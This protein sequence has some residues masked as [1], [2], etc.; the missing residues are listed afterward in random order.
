METKIECPYCKTEFNYEPEDANQD[1]TL[2][3]DCPNEECEKVFTGSANW[4]FSINNIDKA[5]CL[6]GDTHILKPSLGI[7]DGY[8]MQYRCQLCD[9]HGSIERF[10]KHSI[11]TG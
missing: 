3:I 1:E 9:D 2:W 8:P 6:N 4:E 7:P 10:K 11:V 5:D